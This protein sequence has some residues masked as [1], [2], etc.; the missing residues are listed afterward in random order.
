MHKSLTKTI[1][2][3]DAKLSGEISRLNGEFRQLSEKVTNLQLNSSMSHR[4]TAMDRIESMSK[5]NNVVVT[6]V[7]KFN[8]ENLKNIAVKIAAVCTHSLHEREIEAAYRIQPN[9]S[10]P[11]NYNAPI[12]VKFVNLQSKTSFYDSYVKQMK[13]KKFVTSRMLG[14]ETI[15]QIYINHHMTT[16]IGHLFAK[17]LKLKKQKKLETVNAKGNVLQI[18][19]HGHWKK[20]KTEAELNEIIDELGI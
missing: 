10:K 8:G 20:V 14:F 16:S 13:T 2:A 15:S 17:A 12:V 1:Q 3:N 11:D 9:S 4:C 18:K 5:R 6:G 7:P 19:V